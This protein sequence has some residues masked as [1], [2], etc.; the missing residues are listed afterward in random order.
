M[1]VTIRKFE[2]GLI[3]ILQERIDMMLLLLPMEFLAELSGYL[4]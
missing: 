2:S 1:I 3:T 4:I